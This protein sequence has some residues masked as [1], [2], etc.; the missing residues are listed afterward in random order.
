MTRISKTRIVLA[1][2]AALAW[3]ACTDD[4]HAPGNDPAPQQGNA[5][6]GSDNTFNHPDSEVDVWKLLQQLQ[7]QGPPKYTARV[8]SCPK[9][10]YDTIGRV[11]ASRGVNIG[12][13]TPL[14]AGQ[15]YQ[16]SEQALAVAYYA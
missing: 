7:E 8:H 14:S 5:T 10:K 15:I 2:A 6:G 3:A 4:T 12:D 1:A 9:M 13:T 16:P 11:L